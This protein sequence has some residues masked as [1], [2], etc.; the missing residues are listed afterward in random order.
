M[1]NYIWITTQKEGFHFWKY[2]P[3]EVSFLRNPHRHIFK[4]KVYIELLEHNDR[5]IEF[6][7]FKDKVDKLIHEVWQT[8]GLLNN[9][10]TGCSCEMMSDDLNMLIGELYP[11]RDIMI[12]VS[13]D[14]ENGSFKKYPKSQTI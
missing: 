3:E 5:E 2:A 4:F 13:E 1:T 7:I 9:P 8:R 14:G 10:G 11:G 12:E 6:F